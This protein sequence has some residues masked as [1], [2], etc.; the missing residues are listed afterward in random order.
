MA[1]LQR[2]L[3][4]VIFT[5]KEYQYQEF[6]VVAIMGKQGSPACG[7]TETWYN[8]S[9]HGPGEGVYIREL[10][11]RLAG[12]NMDIPVHGI[13]DFKQEEAIE[14]LKKRV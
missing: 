8:E 4:D 5:I 10:K 3:D 11:K 13:A 14:W 1:R 2:I 7:V 9:G 6:E 12:E